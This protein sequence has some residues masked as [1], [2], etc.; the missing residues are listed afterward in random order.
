MN[1]LQ[2]VIDFET[3]SC[4]NLPTTGAIEYSKHE[5][6][7]AL[8]LGYK[9]NNEPAKL[10][11]PERAP[12]PAALWECFKHGTLVA[13]NA[14]FE[15]AI[16]R[17][18]LP[19]Y[20]TLTSEQK[21]HLAL[22][23]ETRW[24][25]TAAKAAAS[26]LPRKLEMAC[27]VLGLSTQKDKDGHR[28]MLKYRKPRRPSKNNPKL[29][30]DDKEELRRI[31]RYCLTDVNAEYELDQTLPDLTAYEQ[32]VWELDQRIND[33]GVL[34]DIP[35]VKT[36]LGMIKEETAN[37]TH[38]VRALSNGTIDEVTQR[39]K[40]L[41]WVNARGAGMSNLQAHTIRD[42]L[43]GLNPK[44][45][46]ALMLTYRQGGS[47][48]STAKYHSM[49][50]AVGEDHRAREMLLYCGTMPTARWSG[51]RVQPQ[52]FPRPTIKGFNS[53][54]AIKLINSGG[55]KAIRAEYGSGK[56]MDVL[57]SCVRG[58]L[59]A[60][61]GCELHCADFSA[62]EAR[63]AFWVAEHAEGVRAFEEDRKLYEEMAAE[64]FGMSLEDVMKDSLE[65]F[66]GKESV[67]GCQY[68]LGWLKF[69]K[70]C[71]KKGMKT[72][73]P[74]IAKKAVYTYRKIH[75]PIP[76]FWKNI[77][78][79]TVRAILHPSQVFKVTKVS[80]YVKGDF[81]NI[82]LPSGRRLRYFK[83]RISHKQL[84]N[85]R[86]VPQIHHYTMDSY[87]KQWIEIVTWGGVLTNHIVQGISRDLMVNGIFNIE[88][89]GYR[90]L[91]SVH[92]EGL[93]QHTKGLGNLEE[94][95]NLMTRLPEWAIGAPVKAEGW[96]GPRYRK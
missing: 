16:T 94:Y 81:L 65:R 68:G 43:L 4:S 61:P 7:S 21:S 41:K 48:T 96:C 59:I 22:I 53:D 54:H 92:D 69:L 42:K 72:V 34:I 37:I 24:R 66:I 44:S 87:T 82:K 46:I 91:L 90:F 67:L 51:K 11:I 5:S 6:T 3:R 18:T 1:H 50:K 12:M 78:Q 38:Q 15:R 28:L 77:E 36:I 27:E 56:V 75:H 23:P 85:G 71:H 95:I 86:M 57:V 2:A 52:N 60:S 29:W 13:H 49:I 14:S 32:K 35:T 19:R 76:T 64:T 93:S 26:H 40:V 45:D 30:W 55:L 70:N 89:S 73:T 80:V 63:I 17:H 10:W 20:D 25:C 8:C 84:S 79:A 83:P 33:F 9:I 88:K 31:Y 39:D 62:I 74:E 47:K 58:M